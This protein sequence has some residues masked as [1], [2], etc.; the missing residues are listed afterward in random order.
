MTNNKENS[1]NRLQASCQHHDSYILVTYDFP[2]HMAVILQWSSRQARTLS[3]LWQG[4]QTHILGETQWGSAR[5]H[6][7][8]GQSQNLKPTKHLCLELLVDIFGSQNAPGNE[9]RDKD[10]RQHCNLLTKDW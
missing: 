1:C 8:P 5:L 2:E 10:P 7:A 6:N 4:A 9:A 3:D